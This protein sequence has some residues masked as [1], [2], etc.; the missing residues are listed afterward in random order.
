MR[1]GGSGMHGLGSSVLL[2]GDPSRGS[3][4]LQA[5]ERK[6][7]GAFYTDAQVAD[8]LVWWAVR[9]ADDTVLDPC[10]GGGVFLDSACRRAVSLSGHPSEQIYGVEIDERVHADTARSLD[11]AYGV[12]P[13]NLLRANFFELDATSIPA[14]DAVVGNPPFIRYQRFNGSVRAAAGFRV[15]EQGIHLSNLSSSWAPFLIHSISLLR[16]GGRLAMVIPAEIG[17]ASYS[18]PVVDFLFRSFGSVM[19]LTF[20][21]RLS[22]R[23]SQDTVLLLAEKKGESTATLL[24]RDLDNVTLLH[25]IMKTGRVEVEGTQRLERQA[26]ASGHLRLVRKLMAPPALDLYSKLKVSQETTRLG[27]ITDVGI[28]YVTGANDFF[29]LSDD[30]VLQYRIPGSFLRPAVR[31]GRDL[32]GIRYT[33]HDWLARRTQGDGVYL[34]SIP[35]D[36]L[37]QGG[38]WSIS[39]WASGWGS[40]RHTNAAYVLPGIRCLTSAVQMPFFPT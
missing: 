9:S 12:S 17:H 11:V 18:V 4:L 32:V 16:N 38:A 6:D 19:I 15:R 23:L 33:A 36:A 2:K 27:D 24:W 7:L 1:T 26:L 25:Q 29:H 40:T 5:T 30:T 13:A 35:P 8:F 14:P 22:P 37:P 21:K 39:G 10:F 3:F 34:L 20:R 28:G 31:R